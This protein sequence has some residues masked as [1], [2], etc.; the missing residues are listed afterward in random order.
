MRKIFVLCSLIILA[1]LATLLV[2]QTPLITTIS[3]SN[4]QKAENGTKSFPLVTIEKIFG[5]GSQI[6]YVLDPVKIV[7]ILATG[8]V[9]PGRSVN[10]QTTVKNDFT[11]S[12]Q[13]TKGVLKQADLT[14]INFEVPLVDTCGGRRGQPGQ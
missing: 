5:G 1:V 11:W 3:I 14:Y 7:T 6:H 4:P 13:N 2:K 12:W 9:V 10:W 8:D